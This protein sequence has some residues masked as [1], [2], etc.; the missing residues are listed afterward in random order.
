MSTV[1]FNNEYGTFLDFRISKKICLYILS[2]AFPESI[3]NKRVSKL[4][5]VH[6][7]IKISGK[8]LDA[9]MNAP[10][11]NYFVFLS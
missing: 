3:N 2:N 8:L 11:G 6:F 1:A 7:S 10:F 9:L 5:S 4:Y